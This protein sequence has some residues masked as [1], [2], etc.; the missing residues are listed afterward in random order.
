MGAYNFD[1]VDDY[2]SIN[3]VL[4]ITAYPFTIGAWFRLSGSTTCTLASLVDKDVANIAHRLG[5]GGAGPAVQVGTAS[6]GTIHNAAS[7]TS[8]SQSTW[9]SC[10][11]VWAASNS[12]RAYLDAGGKVVVTTSRAYSS[13]IDR[14]SIGRLMNS[15]PQDPTDGHIAYV[16]VWNV[17]LSDSEIVD[18][19]NGSIPQ[20][21][22][23]VA[24]YDL[25]RDWGAGPVEDWVNG[26][27]LTISGATYD[28][29]VTPPVTY[30]LG[31]VPSDKFFCFI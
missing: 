27:D 9:Y 7:S 6:S 12:R 19:D 17:A 14:F 16:F 5:I 3:S 1:G 18:W 20:Q 25:T 26:F 21:S 10:T 30:N 22:N 23:L 28:S 24:V 31:G 2:L 13:A 11:G 8:A 29:G 15:T 4:G